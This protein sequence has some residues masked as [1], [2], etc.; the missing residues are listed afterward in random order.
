MVLERLVLVDRS[1]TMVSAWRDAF[2]DDEG[3]EVHDEQ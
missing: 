3:V 1:A 2:G